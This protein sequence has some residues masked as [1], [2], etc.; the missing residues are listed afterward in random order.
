MS[1]M[2]CK[3]E[4]IEALVI[5]EIEL[6][7]L[8]SLS[9][10]DVLYGFANDIENY[11]DEELIKQMHYTLFNMAKK[12]YIYIDEK[13]NII[14]LNT[15]IYMYMEI[16]KFAKVIY[17]IYRID[18]NEKILIY[19]RDDDLVILRLSVTNQKEYR[20]CSFEK[21]YIG[22]FLIDEGYV[23]CIE[24]INDNVKINASKEDK[25]LNIKIMQIDNNKT[26]GER[27]CVSMVEDVNIYESYM[28]Y[29]KT[30]IRKIL[31]LNNIIECFV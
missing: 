21:K 15:K 13:K 6:M 31:T 5:N 18:R 4:K 17:E 28:L 19:K 22:E 20:L 12:E 23:R 26:V 8:F 25:M 30:N 29:G 9:K 7:T 14:K 16:I 1:N 24:N 10:I 27:Y 2:Q 3:L 11:S